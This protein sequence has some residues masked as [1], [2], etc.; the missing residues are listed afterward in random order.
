MESKSSHLSAKVVLTNLGFSLQ[1]NQEINLRKNQEINLQT[2]QETSLQNLLAKVDFQNPLQRYN[3]LRMYPWKTWKI[4]I[5]TEIL[6][7]KLLIRLFSIM[8]IEMLILMKN[9]I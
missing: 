9:E 8:L 7:M 1:K 4:R 6:K 3:H 5:K 2:N